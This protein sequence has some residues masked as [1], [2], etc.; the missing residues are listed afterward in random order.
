MMDAKAAT[1]ASAVEIRFDGT[2]TE[3]MELVQNA[4]TFH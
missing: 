1:N 2:D 3:S 4:F